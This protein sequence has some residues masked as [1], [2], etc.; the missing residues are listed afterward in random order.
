MRPYPLGNER[1]DVTRHDEDGRHRDGRQ[2]TTDR[3]HSRPRQDE[4]PS[5]DHDIGSAEENAVALD[6]AD[7]IESGGGNQRGGLLDHLV[8]LD[9]LL[10]DVQQPDSRPL[11]AVFGAGQ[12]RPH[13]RELEQLLG[14][15]LGIGAKVQHVHVAAG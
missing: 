9:L 7:V 3:F 2:Q 8:T 12:R 4:C 5:G 1:H 13:H 15:A 14:A 6:E 10:T 11:E